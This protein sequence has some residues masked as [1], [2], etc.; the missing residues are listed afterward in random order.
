MESRC[1]VLYTFRIIYIYI[2]LCV[3]SAR[4]VARAQTRRAP[5]APVVCPEGVESQCLD[6][7]TDCVLFLFLLTPSNPIGREES[8]TYNQYMAV[9][10]K[11]D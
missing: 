9:I 1:V 6:Y 5:P 11:C 8:T 4:G 7:Y 3:G 10:G 2:R